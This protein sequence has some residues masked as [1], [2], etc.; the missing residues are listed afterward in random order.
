GRLRPQRAGHA[1][2]AVVRHAAV[3]QRAHDLGLRRPSMEIGVALAVLS[4]L[5][6][7]PDGAAQ[8]SASWRVAHGEVRVTWPLPG[9]GSFEARTSAISG[10]LAL[11]SPSPAA[12]SGEIAVDLKTL[13]TGIALRNE[14]LRDKYLETGKGDGFETAVLSDIRLPDADAAVQG[15]TRF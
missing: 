1:I 5:V 7:A 4:A 8:A 10:T 6:F 15:K 3:G 13:E 11:A 12:L 9:G 2:A 14:H